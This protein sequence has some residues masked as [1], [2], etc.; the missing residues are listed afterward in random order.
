MNPDSLDQLRKDITACRACVHLPYSAILPSP[1]Y[2]WGS[3]TPRL[4]IYGINPPVDADRC[5]HGAWMIHYKD[6]KGPHEL[7]VLELLTMMGIQPKE[8]YAGNVARCPTEANHDVGEPVFQNC[9]RFLGREL[10]LIQPKVIL[11]FGTMPYIHIFHQMWKLHKSYP[12][13]VGSY[14]TTPVGG[15]RPSN[16]ELKRHQNQWIISAP[17]PSRVTRFIE[18]ESWKDAITDAFAAIPD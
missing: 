6:N 13:H 9:S 11:A 15:S 1:R 16:V 14:D 4:A 18:K 17:H 2:G 12:R 7:L 8:V 3:K 5:L 10:A